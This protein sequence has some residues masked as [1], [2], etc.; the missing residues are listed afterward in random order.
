VKLEAKVGDKVTVE[1][2]SYKVKV[3]H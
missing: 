1:S 3:A 2:K